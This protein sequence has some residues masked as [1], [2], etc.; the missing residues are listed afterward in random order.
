MLSVGDTHTMSYLVPENKTVPYVIPESDD[1]KSMPKVFAT[2][3]LVGATEWACMDALRPHLDPDQTSVGIDIDISHEAATLPG[4][5][6][7]FELTVTE[8]GERTVTWEVETHDEA[9][10]ISR[11]T[12]SRAVIDKQRFIQ[13]VNARASECHLPGVV[14]A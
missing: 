7:T 14:L 2:A 12:H 10:V 11:G 9:G 4:M 8:V 13:S 3:F 6:L 1:F 5:T